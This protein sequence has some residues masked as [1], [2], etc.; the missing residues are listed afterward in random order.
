MPP[1]Y[2]VFASRVRK[3][4]LRFPCLGRKSSISGWQSLPKS[5]AIMVASSNAV[6]SSH[7]VYEHVHPVPTR[8]PTRALHSTLE[9]DAKT[10][11]CPAYPSQMRVYIQYR[12]ACLWIPLLRSPWHCYAVTLA[13]SVA[14]AIS[15]AICALSCSAILL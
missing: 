10:L 11:R 4:R 2:Q 15:A 6:N 9:K 3:S 5:F 13:P 8:A 14:L 7:I 12:L 1:S